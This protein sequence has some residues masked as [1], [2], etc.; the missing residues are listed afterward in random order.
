MLFWKR[1]RESI[2]QPPG[3]RWTSLLAAVAEAN[4]D[5]MVVVGPEDGGS[6][7]TDWVGAVVSVSGTDRRFPAMVDAIE[8]GLFHEGCRHK[9]LPYRTD[10]GEAE[11]LFCT[12]IA[13]AGMAQRIR[14]RHLSPSPAAN[15]ADTEP[16]AEFTRVYDLARDAEK[17]KQP[18]IALH[19]CQEALGLLGRSEVFNNDDQ[20]MV[21][22]VLKGR[23]QTIFR[24][25]RP[26]KSDAP[27]VE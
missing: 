5:L 18:E 27:G 4:S 10:D 1:K 19:Y 23:M 7:C 15:T 6:V 20:V 24:A 9:L 22:R 16:R 26:S 3:S 17:A 13:I 8:D 14:D 2:A 12:K 21:E 11:A 25:Q